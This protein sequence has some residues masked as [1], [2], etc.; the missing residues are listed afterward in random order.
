MTKNPADKLSDRPPVRD[1]RQSEPDIVE[2]ASMDSF[3]AS[4]PPPWTLGR[5]ECMGSRGRSVR[6][7]A[8]T[9]GINLRHTTDR[10]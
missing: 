2:L 1:R 5:S 6:Q 10:F 4:D 8:R 3:P 9:V 7:M